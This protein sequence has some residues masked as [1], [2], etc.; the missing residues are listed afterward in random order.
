LCSCFISSVRNKTSDDKFVAV[1]CIEPQFFAVMMEKLPI[2]PADYGKQND[3]SL[4]SAQHA[5]L[6]E[7]FAAETRDHWERMFALTDACVTP[8]LDYVEAV[9]HPVNVARQAH[10]VDEPWMQPQIA[11][12]LGD[13]SLANKFSIPEKGASLHDV[14]SGAGYDDAMIAELISSGGAAES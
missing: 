6:A 9:A 11:P 8:V 10:I 1:G 4:W 5:M 2:D 3:R 14:M 13:Q 7:I 12:R